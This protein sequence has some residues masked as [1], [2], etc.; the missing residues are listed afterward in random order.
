MISVLSDSI[1]TAN[2]VLSRWN[3]FHYC[4]IEKPLLDDIEEYKSRPLCENINRNLSGCDNKNRLISL[5]GGGGK[6]HVLTGGAACLDVVLEVG[7]L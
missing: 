1:K 2:L 5:W 4:L 3:R 7:I 6:V